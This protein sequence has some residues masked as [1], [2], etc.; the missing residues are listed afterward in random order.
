MDIRGVPTFFYGSFINVDV[1]RGRGF[2]PD[3]IEVARLHGWDIRIRPLAN[4]VRSERDCVY[5]V[6]ASPTHSDLS[7]LYAYAKDVL[8]GAYLPEAVL[9]ETL[10]GARQPALC[11]LAQ[12]MPDAPPTA[13]YVDRIVRP[14][15]DLGFPA[16]YVERLERFKP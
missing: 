2:V 15:R 6:L 10:D 11:Y 12:E 9:V 1:L 13:E 3:R 14:A 16:W 7:R 8:R 4:L 5:G